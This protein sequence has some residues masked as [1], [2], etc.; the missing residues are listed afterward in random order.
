ML[1]FLLFLLDYCTMC[2]LYCDRKGEVKRRRIRG[3]SK[4]HKRGSPPLS[5]FKATLLPIPEAHMD[6]AED[7]NCHPRKK[8]RHD[9]NDSCHLSVDTSLPPLN[10]SIGMDAKNKNDDTS[11]VVHAISPTCQSPVP[12]T[13]QQS[14]SHCKTKQ[15]ISN[16]IPVDGDGEF[17]FTGRMY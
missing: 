14:R 4:R 12:K 6:E 7:H 3:K 8:G 13:C 10:T 15:L 9:R 16:D 17:K 2:I 11:K 5:S 1:P